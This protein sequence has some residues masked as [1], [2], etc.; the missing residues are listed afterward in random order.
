MTAVNGIDVPNLKT[1]IEGVRE[2]RSRA[3]RGPTV[4]ATWQGVTRAALEM[5]GRKG[6]H[7]GGDDELNAMQTLLGALGAC[8]IEVIVT[9][10]ALMG[11]QIEDLRIEASGHF[12]VASLLGVESPTDAGYQE[13]SYKVVIDAPGAT[14]DQIQYLKD[15]C[16]RFSPVGDSL[17]K[18]VPLTLEFET[19]A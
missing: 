7:I 9:H 3:D 11:L 1:Y 12:N 14:M 8:D 4:V 2:D 19:T 13:V 5:D 16:E 6:L 18:H 17:R 15:S 10:A